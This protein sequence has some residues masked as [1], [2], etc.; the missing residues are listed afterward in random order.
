MSHSS[1]WFSVQLQA[2]APVVHS[3]CAKNLKQREGQC[4]SARVGPAACRGHHGCVNRLNWNES[5]SLL[6][7]GSDD[8]KANGSPW[9]MLVS[10]AVRAEPVS[11]LNFHSVRVGCCD[12]VAP[13]VALITARLKGGRLFCRPSSPAQVMLWSYPDT[14]RQPIALETEHQANIVSDPVG[15]APQGCCCCQPGRCSAGRLPAQVQQQAE[16]IHR[17]ARAPPSR[18]SPPPGYPPPHH[19]QFG[20]RFLPQT[21]DARLVT[22]AMDYTVQAGTPA[23]AGLPQMACMT[24]RLAGS[25]L[26]DCLVDRSQQTSLPLRALLES[27][28][29]GLALC[30]PLDTSQLHAMSA[31]LLR[32]PLHAAASAGHPACQHEAA[33]AHRQWRR[34]QP[35]QPKRVGHAGQR[36]HCRLHMPSQPCEGESCLRVEPGVGC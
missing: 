28:T 23:W 10:Q 2:L 16:C 7:S 29:L 3:P 22:G 32:L 13:D 5:G 15:R 19:L 30:C 17:C 26:G 24:W 1:P 27:W 8:R 4:P 35:P 14:Q 20:V 6:A 18:S 9:R 36:T 12:G 21:S 33:G 31:A 25:S 34:W 11:D